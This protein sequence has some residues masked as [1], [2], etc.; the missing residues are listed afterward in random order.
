MRP[1]DFLLLVCQANFVLDAREVCQNIAIDWP[2][3]GYDRQDA[4]TGHCVA[5]DVHSLRLKRQAHR[6]TW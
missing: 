2:L 6:N 4:G 5:S 1:F 3:T